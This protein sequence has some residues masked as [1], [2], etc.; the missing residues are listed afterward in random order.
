MQRQQAQLS[1]CYSKKEYRSAR[2]HRAWH[3][4]VI[5]WSAGAES[6]L[7]LTALLLP[8]GWLLDRVSGVRNSSWRTAWRK[9]VDERIQALDVGLDVKYPEPG[10]N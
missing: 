1:A 5:T 8:E 7:W 9:D 10:K 3:G 6:S 2:L 4:G